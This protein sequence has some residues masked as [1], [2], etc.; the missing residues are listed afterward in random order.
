MNMLIRDLVTWQL[1]DPEYTNTKALLGHSFIWIQARSG[2]K[3]GERFRIH[4][5]ETLSWWLLKHLEYLEQ[6]V[7]S[8]VWNYEQIDASDKS[9]LKASASNVYT[10]QGNA[11]KWKTNIR[12][13]DSNVYKFV[14]IVA[15]RVLHVVQ[16]HCKVSQADQ[17]AVT[18]LLRGCTPL[19]S[20]VATP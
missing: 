20:L 2:L 5:S 14:E 12:T 18:H 6:L 13:S 9:A 8:A 15:N 7:N 17:S 1:K 4:V 11:Q 16:M 3:F 19:I 10:R